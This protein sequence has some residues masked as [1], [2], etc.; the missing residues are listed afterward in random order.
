MSTVDLKD[1][2]G[3]GMVPATDESAVQTAASSP[4]DRPPREGTEQNAGIIGK[5]KEK[6]SIWRRIYT[7]LT[8]TPPNCRWDPD[9]PPQFSM[10]STSFCKM[11]VIARFEQSLCYNIALLFSPREILCRIPANHHPLSE[12]PFRLCRRLYGRKPLLQPPHP[13]PT[14]CR[15]QRTL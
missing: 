11:H 15:L 7:I 12:R 2:G 3:Q 4:T 6:Q 10:S 14:S 13:Q 9:K 8:W 1:G 5:E